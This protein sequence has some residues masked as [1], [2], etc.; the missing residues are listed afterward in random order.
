MKKLLIF[1]LILSAG[2]AM[3]ANTTEIP[4]TVT[5][6]MTELR[7]IFQQS[8]DKIEVDFLDSVDECRDG[9]ARSLKQA[10]DMA[11][12]KGD[13][14]AVVEIRKEKARFQEDRAVDDEIR[15]G[16]HALIKSCV[17]AY[18]NSLERADQARSQQVAI[19]AGKYMQH[20][21]AMKKKLTMEK[22]IDDALV[23][24]GE[25]KR[26]KA[27]PTISQGMTTKA[28]GPGA[29]PACGGKKVTGSKCPDCSGSGDCSYCEGKGTR[30]ALGGAPTPCFG[31]T[32]AKK[33]KK[34]SGEGQIS[35]TCARCGG[36]G[37]VR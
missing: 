35:H 18:L 13:L 10:E 37:R 22:N 31:C 20:L 1:A 6:Q 23:V 21:E 29:C 16:T 14:D 9:Y 4:K 24:S 17:Q 25:I 11:T 36:T 27:D 33:C 15:P 34:C 12:K 26:A 32:G 3:A 2:A 8:L 19:L 5:D 28:A 30:P 7:V